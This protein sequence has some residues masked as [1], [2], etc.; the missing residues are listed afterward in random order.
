M[1]R[2]LPR[3]LVSLVHHIELNKAG[4]WDKAIQQFVLSVMW[5]ERNRSMTLSD[6]V[7]K[8][9]TEFNVSID[10]VKVQKQIDLLIKEGRVIRLH[11][12]RFKLSEIALGQI[13]KLVQESEAIEQHVKNKFMSI[14]E[15]LCPSLDAYQVWLDFH[16]NFLVQF[17]SDMGAYAFH[18][19]AEET[20]TDQLERVGKEYFKRFILK[21]SE[22]KMKDVVAKFL[23]PKDVLVRLYILR[24]M[25]AYFYIEA[26]GLREETLKNLVKM[27]QRKPSFQI[28]VDT[29]FL[30]SILNLHDNPSNEAAKAL[31]ELVRRLPSEVRVKF[32]VTPITIEEAKRVLI[33]IKNYLEGIRITP[34]LLKGAERADFPGIVRTFLEACK[35]I[36]SLDVGSYFDPYI[37][38]LLEIA[39]EKGVDLYNQK[40]DDYK[41]KQKVIDDIEEQRQIEEKRRGDRAKRYEALEH[42]M[43]LWHFVK[44]KRPAYIESPLDARYWIVTVD[45]RFIAFDRSKSK[46]N[47]VPICIH[48][49]ALIQMLQFWVPRTEELEAALFASLRLPLFFSEFDQEAEKVTIE[50]LR[51]LSRFENLEDLPE[52]T[53]ANLLL[54]EALKTKM[55]ATHEEEQRIELIREELINEQARLK[56]ELEEKQRNLMEKEREIAINT[57]NIRNL[58]KALEEEK[59]LRQQL[60][61]QLR[62]AQLEI[63]DLQEKIRAEEEYMREKEK[64]SAVKR[65]LF[66]WIS[67]LLTTLLLVG[68]IVALVASIFTELSLKFWVV[69]IE[70]GLLLLWL[71]IV[72]Y[73]ARKAQIEHPLVE[74][75]RKFKNWILG[76]L[77]TGILVNALW[78]LIKT[79]IR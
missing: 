77:I 55:L 14:V 71:F 53:I 13:Q 9:R 48:P 72:D 26:S 43:A 24:M 23:D 51:T 75:I 49:A 50:I 62:Q 10:S 2:V 54:N 35:Q 21:Y 44:D 68:F 29:N 6:V 74:K 41:M 15:Q 1:P 61:D 60:E 32:Y 19:I 67:A 70:G 11:D 3:E 39:R 17:V 34:N 65:F 27:S 31:V 78:D 7:D 20:P 4:W 52:E 63:R 22:H 28:F 18:L 38:N 16:D 45:Y 33:S 36:P 5:F 42:D 76:A 58:E 79:M 73:K 25:N 57:E 46:R 59:R 8:L 37:N 69:T 64:R 30:F 66:W 56:R 47:E 12:G 40:I